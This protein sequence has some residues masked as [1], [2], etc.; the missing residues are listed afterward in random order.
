MSGEQPDDDDGDEDFELEN[1]GQAGAVIQHAI[2]YLLEKKIDEL[3]IASALL[4]G[5]LSVLSHVLDAEAIERIL[6]NAIASVRAGELSDP[7]IADE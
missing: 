6:T 2:S 3:A 5:A 1:L 7:D 4:G